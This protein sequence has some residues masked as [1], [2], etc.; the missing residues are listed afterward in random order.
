MTTRQRAKVMLR[1]AVVGFVVVTAN[2]LISGRELYVQTRPLPMSDAAIQAAADGL[3]AEI[4]NAGPENRDLP[5]F[6]RRQLD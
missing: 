6:A 1:L 5:L 3:L 4:T 2:P